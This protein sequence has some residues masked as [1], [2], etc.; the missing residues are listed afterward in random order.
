MLSLALPKGSSLEERTLDLFATAG[1]KVRRS[2]PHTYR[3]SIEYG[4][5]IEVAFYKPREIPL[6]VESGSFD[7]GL[8]GADWIEEAAA[9]VETLETFTYSKLTDAPWRIVLA[10]PVEHPARHAGELASGTRVASE[11]VNLGRKFFLDTGLNVHMVRSYGATE[12]KI[13]ELADAV[14]DVVET[15]DSLRH[16]GLRILET[17]CTCAPQVI[18]SP[19]SLSVESKR[20]RIR[21][22]VHR[23]SAAG[24]GRSRVLITSRVPVQK[25]SA[26]AP[27]MPVGSWRA[28]VD[29]VDADI[30]VL[31]GLA[32][33]T[34]L[35]TVTDAIL[36]AGA[37]EVTE[38][39][40]LKTMSA[41]S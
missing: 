33:V 9:K 29:L 24:P 11:Y 19:A 6:V 34:D 3:G 30:V 35:V 4:G 18:A 14:I 39:D 32:P 16:N 12:A 28:G 15:G 38:S 23:L 10:V 27:L 41:P 22:V 2:S 8:T 13:P 31:Q 1:L 40:V 7:F 20:E 36:R 21:S 5:G 26:V 17:I 25:L 37:M